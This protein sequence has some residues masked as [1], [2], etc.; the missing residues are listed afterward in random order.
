MVKK[1]SAPK[2][3]PAKRAGTTRTTAKVTPAPVTS[4]I[5][6]TRTYSIPD[7]RL[8]HPK[9]RIFQS[10]EGSSVEYK[11]EG[12]LSAPAPP[13][14]D[15]KYL[16]RAQC[17][18]LYRWMILNRRMEAALENL[19]KQ[20]KVVG[21][22]YFGLGQEGCSCASAMALQ[23]DDWLGPMIRNQ[24]A[25]LVRGYLPRDIM[26]QYMAKA[27]SPTFGR[28]ASSH[29]GDWEH[30]HVCAPISML[31]ELIGV[32]AGVCLGARLQGRD[33]VGLTYIGDG[34]QST[35]VTYESL[36]FAA[37][38][39]LGLVLIVE[40]NLWGYSTPSDMQFRVQDLAERAI[41]YGIPGVIVDGTDPC[42]VYDATHE[43]CERARRGEGPTLI[44]AKMMRMKGHAIHD[45]AQYVP[46]EL[47][48][49]WRARDPIA[50]FE[51]WLVK[52]RWLS[53]AENDEL[54]A[55]VE[56]ELEAERDVAVASPMPDPGTDATHQGVYCDE[57]CHTIKPLYGPVKSAERR[58]EA[59]GRKSAES[60]VHL[61]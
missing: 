46:A 50:R 19:Y 42:Q 22:V 56:R 23:A 54:I 10:G 17:L 60:A 44:E 20:G 59:A 28:D 39:R 4:V 1:K 55:E 43:A 11:I 49:Y 40:N 52:K 58:K 9:F 47:F 38:Q 57:A 27:D 61:K 29:F 37:V 15:S 51:N 16:S 18:A 6:Q 2:K 21:G 36:N 41:A 30:R 26:R 14:R 24:G 33:I 34:G 3:S 32:M 5:A 13:I 31:G 8:E 12:D 45:A 7:H 35:G 53:V 25:S 48:E